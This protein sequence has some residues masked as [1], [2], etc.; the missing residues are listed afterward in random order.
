MKGDLPVYSLPALILFSS[1][2]NANSYFESN[3]YDIKKVYTSSKITVE[4]IESIVPLSVITDKDIERYGIQSFEQLFL[5]IPQLSV[6]FDGTGIDVSNNVSVLEPLRM[7]V[8]I[9]GVVAYGTGVLE[10]HW[11]KLPITISQI[12]RVEVVHSPSSSVYGSNAFENVINIITKKPQLIGDQVRYIERGFERRLFA[13]A[14][15]NDLYDENMT[16]TFFHHTGFS[17]DYVDSNGYEHLNSP[18]DKLSLKTRSVMMIGDDHLVD[19]SLSFTE[20]NTKH[21][22]SAWKEQAPLN[23][24]KDWAFRLKYENQISDLSFLKITASADIQKETMKLNANF[25]PLLF[26]DETRA[27]VE[28]YGLDMDDLG[29]IGTLPIT[30]ELIAFTQQYVKWLGLG[31]PEYNMNALLKNNTDRYYTGFDYLY[32]LRNDLTV[33]L[34][35]NVRFEDYDTDFAQDKD[36]TYQLNHAS[37]L[38]YH[39]PNHDIILQAAIMAERIKD[40][41]YEFPY[42]L[43]LNVGVSNLVRLRASYDSSYRWPSPYERLGR[44]DIPIVSSEDNPFNI[45]P[46]SSFAF[47]QQANNRYLK[48][49]SVHSSKVGL[50]IESPGWG[51]GF[52]DSVIELT[53]YHNDYDNLILDTINLENSTL[54]NDGNMTRIGLYSSLMGEFDSLFY[55]LGFSWAQDSNHAF[56][57]DNYEDFHQN[58]DNYGFSSAFAYVMED[59]T[60]RGKYFWRYAPKQ[61]N[62]SMYGTGFSYKGFEDAVINL[63]AQYIVNPK[64]WSVGFDN[65][66]ND[67]IISAELVYD[68]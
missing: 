22:D 35:S 59:V 19:L 6:S 64:G 56:T 62:R 17:I 67:L 31:S 46:D 1:L 66:P 8:L 53:A 57:S 51:V 32:N 4:S 39:S 18:W 58:I 10:M 5:M 55:R 26:L 52:S 28:L 20:M 54:N 43:G 13:H 40:Y 11:E 48:P 33:S 23:S 49:E 2:V 68:F 14:L 24:S 47:Y 63:D 34:S 16:S 3:P 25:N 60:I 12:Q 30:P 65:R 41:D 15:I 38:A 45:G 50:I 21:W 61:V 7:Q 27:V 36:S 29:N 44:I 37:E 9:D 42:R